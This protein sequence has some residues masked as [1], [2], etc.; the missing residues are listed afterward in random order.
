M[1]GGKVVLTIK[2]YQS[3]LNHYAA[4]QSIYKA[5]AL[6]CHII[7]GGL[8]SDHLRSSL[9]VTY[10]MCGHIPYARKLFDELPQ[11]SLLSYNIVIRMYVHDRLY[12]DAINVFV[13][14]IG[15]CC[16]DSYTYPFVVKA[17]AE[18]NSI[19]LGSVLHGRILR[20]WFGS[21]RYVQNSLL[22]MYMNC[23]RVE[24]AR[25]VF[26][27]MKNRD[28]ISW[29]TMISGYYRNGFMN[30]ALMTFDRMVYGGVEPDRATVVSVLPVCGH[31]KDLEIGREVHKLAEEK[32]LADKLEVKNA[33][34]NMYMKC[35]RMDEARFVFDR[36]EN[37]DVISW[38][39]MINGYIEDGDLKNALD[40]CRLMQFE[41]V[42][43]NAVTI[44]SL[45]SACGSACELKDGQCLHGW[46]I[47]QMVDSE[48]IIETA[49]ISMYS[50]CK[51]IDL[52]FKVLSGAS[53]KQTGTWSAIIAACVQNQLMRE[54]LELFKR[55]RREDVEPNI[56]TL[57]G[58]LPAFAVVADMRQA[59]D[60]H[61]YLT[62][63]GFMSSIEAST[64]LIDVYSKCGSLESAHKIFD[65]IPRK[66]KCK[67]VVLW[68]ALISGYAIHSDGPNALMVFREMLRSGV[69]P[70]EVTFT[71]VL[72]ACSHTGLVDKGL[73]IFEF[74]LEHHRTA[75]RSNHFTCVVDLLGRADRLKEAYDLISAVPFE[76]GPADWG[77]LLGACVIH[78]NAELGEVAANKLF[79][80][81]PENTGNY[82][83]LMKIYGSMGR[84]KD[85]ENVRNMITSI[86]LR[87]KP[88]LSL[89]Q[90]SG[91]TS[92]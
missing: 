90:A 43:P 51:R 23:G 7:T 72:H 71:S 84:W 29:N 83:L 54:A 10:A 63:S 12:Q 73:T 9:S 55:M 69:K 58:V 75:V 34:V 35:N 17:A 66:Y 13:G 27:G 62:K 14:M 88:G 92:R 16:P 87:K 30:D 48:I 31:L 44:A 11:S 38:T 26:D 28:A 32:G 85:V 49:L 39:S 5:K 64:C 19:K 37:R 80:L 6:H 78:E 18:L 53:E 70:N 24:L 68:S 86:G 47:R 21:D 3:L 4:T 25:K 1:N 33:L 59:M 15:R 22:A 60:I 41:G 20:G 57:N 8:L 81:E 79:E 77:A 74:M 82:M 67:D 52:C 89:V 2:Q 40:L 76:T 42:K 65:A 46:A 91:S 50:K 56:A 36:M 61:C 45:V